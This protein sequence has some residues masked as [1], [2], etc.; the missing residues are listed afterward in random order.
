[1]NHEG[2]NTYRKAQT[3]GKSPGS[4][5]RATTVRN[6]AIAQTAEK[7][8]AVIRVSRA[9]KISVSSIPKYEDIGM[10]GQSGKLDRHWQN[11]SVLTYFNQFRRNLNDIPKTFRFW[12]HRWL[13]EQYN[14][15]GW[16]F[17]NWTN[18]ED[19]LNYVC[20]M[21]ISF[22]DLQHILKLKRSDMGLRGKLGIAIGAR[23]KGKALAHFEPASN[24]INLTR[25]KDYGN[26]GELLKVPTPDNPKLRKFLFTGGVGSFAHEYGH[27]LDYWIGGFFDQEPLQ[28]ALSGGTS[29]RTAP[30]I[31][32]MKKKTPRGITEKLLA[33]IIFKR[34]GKKPVF[35]HY[36]KTLREITEGKEYWYQRNE[37]FARAFEQYI[38]FKMSK[39]GSANA[40]LHKLKYDHRVYMDYE[41]L[42]QVAPLFDQL[43]A[44]I[45]KIL[46]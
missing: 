17:G 40:F 32:R 44:S 41:L 12:D 39:A 20:A 28:Y 21:G 11:E 7:E 6:A 26:A 35:T 45:R 8:Q 13:M 14:L 46:K 25:Y 37:L 19:Q 22:Y 36:Y 10:T 18:Q 4:K 43:M 2:K 33:R 24:I 3:R 27:A 29:T 31:E 30:D 42:T 16:E 1:M 5:K 9:Y 34:I 23:G 38:A 15:K